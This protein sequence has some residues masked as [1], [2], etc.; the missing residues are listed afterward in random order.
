[1]DIS[2][3]DFLK[4]TTAG[5]AG[6]A[7]AGILG[8][9]QATEETTQTPQLT[10]SAAG[11]AESKGVLLGDI[12]NPQEDFTAYTTDY[13]HIFSPLKIGGVTMRNRLGKSAAG[14]EMQKRSDWP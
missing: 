11:T 9:C 5:I 2:R 4:G 3:R 7:L 10:D 13:S 1:M 6:L 14:S 12:L 8:R